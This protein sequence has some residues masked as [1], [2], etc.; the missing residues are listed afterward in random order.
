MSLNLTNTNTFLIQNQLDIESNSHIQNYINQ[1]TLQDN[2][3]FNLDTLPFALS[4]FSNPGIVLF[5]NLYYPTISFLTIDEEKNTHS[6]LPIVF[7]DR[8]IINPDNLLKSLLCK[9]SYP[10]VSLLSMDMHNMSFS[11]SQLYSSLDLSK[12]FEK[13]IENFLIYFNNSKPDIIKTNVVKN[14]F[15]IFNTTINSAIVN[16]GYIKK[17]PSFFYYNNL[18]YGNDIINDLITYSNFTH[19]ELDVYHNFKYFSAPDNYH[20]QFSHYINFLNDLERILYSKEIDNFTQAELDN[21]VNNFESVSQHIQSL[22]NPFYMEFSLGDKK[23]NTQLIKFIKDNN[24]GEDVNYYENIIYAIEKIQ[25]L[26]KFIHKNTNDKIIHKKLNKSFFFLGQIYT[27]DDDNM[28]VQNFD[29]NLL[30]YK[31]L[32]Q[33]NLIDIEETNTT[34][35][36]SVKMNKS[37]FSQ[38]VFPQFIDN[39]NNNIN[40]EQHIETLKSITGSVFN[41]HY[42]FNKINNILNISYDF[43]TNNV[44]KNLCNKFLINQFNSL[45]TNINKYI[46]NNNIDP[47][48]FPNNISIDTFMQNTVHLLPYFRIEYDENKANGEIRANILSFLLSQSKKEHPETKV[49]NKI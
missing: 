10:I 25:S 31:E 37:M 3:E 21:L 27:C 16:N 17:F 45:I 43:D 8:E 2:F 1:F 23:L 24:Q 34:R 20:N 41:I 29:N 47:L 18:E 42:S 40:S 6:I 33:N 15:K 48:C 11:T 12:Y 30:D 14:F 32:V 38:F 39:F 35:T 13:A 28:I 26:T 4:F 5:N 49:K 7:K 46:S 9:K 44:S 22:T 36:L 19:L